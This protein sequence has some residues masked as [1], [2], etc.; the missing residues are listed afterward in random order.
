[1][2]HTSIDSSSTQIHKKDTNSCSRLRLI[3][4]PWRKLTFCVLTPLLLFA[5]ACSADL[6][7]KGWQWQE[8]PD[9]KKALVQHFTDP[10]GKIVDQK[11]RLL[12]TNQPSYDLLILPSE[13]KDVD[14]ILQKVSVALKEEPGQAI[15]D[16]DPSKDLL[17]PYN[18]AKIDER[19]NFTAL[20]EQ[21]EKNRSTQPDVPVLIRKNIDRLTMA[22]LKVHAQAL[23]GVKIQLR[24]DNEYHYGDMTAHIIGGL[25]ESA[26]ETAG[27][28]F[29]LQEIPLEKS[30]PSRTLTLTLDAELQKVAEQAMNHEEKAGA[31]VVMDVNSG[32]LLAA[33]S[34]PGL[35]MKDFQGGISS[36][37]WKNLFDDPKR[38]L[39]NKVL[40][41]LYPPGSTYKMVTALTGLAKGVITPETTFDC[42]GHIIEGT[43]RYNCWKKEGHGAVDLKKA[44]SESCDVYFYQVGKQVGVDALAEYA[45]KLGLGIK[46]DVA[47]DYEKS[48]LAPTKAWRKE[49]YNENWQDSD[50]LPLSI[51]QGFNLATPL[52][53]CQM[54]ATIANG[55]KRFVPQIVESLN[56]T[57]GQ[58]MEPFTAKLA[59][60]LLEN[61]KKH[62]PMIQEAMVEAVQGTN[63]T[64]SAV[65]IKGLTI[66]GKTGTGQVVRPEE[67]RKLQGEDIP[68]Q[69]RDHAWFTCYAPADK[70]E[71]AVTVLVEH[72][73][74]GSLA[75]PVAK[76]VLQKYFAG[77]IEKQPEMLISGEGQD[78][79]PSTP[80]K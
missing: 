72:G 37:N 40:Q 39:V 1:M 24:I 65:H 44:M 56:G 23:P 52:Q 80:K 67:Y 28:V 53:I 60:E 9:G 31:V 16:S 46:T 5:S 8:T 2:L 42:P 6:P 14:G 19:N 33:I 76:A 18:E 59:G 30:M 68:Y 55:G 78:A 7:G 29:T 36:K 41:S 17:V 70:P 43:R 45:N 32:K 47:L 74:H 71:I 34:S 15:V 57:Y 66:G 62:L 3:L 38:P 77:R 63:G 35:N 58:V 26:K 25:P 50:T 51:G 54:T 69:Y 49:K 10:K 13:A 21:F 48:G 11:G 79:I 61:E 64:A 27:Q 12:V 22:H 73:Q 20:K 4:L 75:I